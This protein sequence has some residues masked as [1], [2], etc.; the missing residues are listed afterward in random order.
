MK[1]TFALTI[2]L[3]LVFSLLPLFAFADNSVSVNL[4]EGETISGKYE[5]IATGAENIGIEIDGESVDAGIGKPYF[6]FSAAGI[7]YGGGNVYYGDTTFT[8]LPSTSGEFK[9]EFYES[10]LGDGE[11]VLTYVAAS[12][13]F[14][15]EDIPVY[16]TYNIDDQQVTD[17][18]VIL[19]N[20]QAVIPDSVILHYPVIGTNETKSV[21][22]AYDP[23]KIYSI[24]DGWSAETNLG[25][26]TPNTP[27]YIS[28]VFSDL[29]KTIKDGTGSAAVVDTAKYP[30]GEHI[31]SVI[32][33]GKSLLDVK[34]FTDNTGPSIDLNL[35]FGTVLFPESTIGFSAED[36]SGETKIKSDID[37]QSYRLG[38]DL[39]WLYE[40]KHLLTVTA[41]DV[42]GNTTTA[43][44]E[45]ILCKNV[46]TEIDESFEKQT[47]TAVINGNSQEYIYNIGKAGSFIFEYNGTTSENGSVSISAFDFEADEY[48]EIG[49]A[50]SNVTTTFKIDETRFISGGKVKICVKP[51]IYVSESDTVVWITD[52]QYYSN[53]ED[54]HSVYELIINYAVGLYK[55]Q[56]AGYLIHTGDIV[57][58]Y[59]PTSKANEEWVFADRVHEILDNAGMPN[60]VLAGNH[61]TNNTPADFNNFNKYFGS[62]RFSDNIW[63][64]G[65]LDNN[66]CH[67][68]LITISGTDYLFMYLGNGAEDS[69]RT[70]AWANA[71]CKAYPNRTVIVCVHPY[72]DVNGEYVYNPQ[73]PDTYLHSRAYEIME[74]IIEPNENI[75]AVLCGHVHG[76]CRVQRNVGKSG[77]YI[78]EILSDY[79]YAEVGVEP[80][81]EANGCTLDGEGYLRLITFGENGLM[82][83]TTYSPLHD[84]YNYFGEEQDTFS[85]TLLTQ[86][87]NVTVVTESA[88][89]YSEHITNSPVIPVIICS[90]ILLF[91]A[92]IG[93]TL[94][95][96]KKGWSNVSSQRS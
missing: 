86:K 93:F 94:L 30:D 20:G 82:N 10:I 42:Y 33:N 36:L 6:S 35:E 5:F 11:V 64:G 43:C 52:T 63:Y 54:L 75:A 51:N 68:D 46:S 78:W 95:K 91:S 18:S 50:Q 13:G 55:E 14:V 70:V 23:S 29:L 62:R 37:G 31:L 58:T 3:L 79:Q 15:Y 66:T 40:G 24:G 73:A 1:K 83:Q 38:Q 90:C 60:G 28:F 45:F 96:K 21:S 7:D 25:G 85:V 22:E 69:Q 72:L 9:M 59:S 4:Y 34:F 49:F 41:S 27:I 87:N 84:D 17:V 53:F 76:A 67:Y 74:H 92:G 71:V 16:G 12:N 47:V 32:A 89:L 26:S 81:H 44:T 56:K 39:S 8:A 80:K 48:V 77:R 57:D 65:S 2:S 61:D 19:A 88:A